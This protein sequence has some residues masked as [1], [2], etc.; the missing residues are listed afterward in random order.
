[1]KTEDTASHGTATLALKCSNTG[2][3]HQFPFIFADVATLNSKILEWNECRIAVAY[4]M[5]TSV[6]DPLKSDPS[7]RGPREEGIKPF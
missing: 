6:L 1:M 3:D 7:H 5:Q 2:I 4:L